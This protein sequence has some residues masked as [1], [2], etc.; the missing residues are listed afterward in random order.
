MVV[1]APSTGRATR[2]WAAAVAAG[3]LHWL[4]F[5]GVGLWPLAF[6]ALVPLYVSRVSSSRTAALAG[7]LTG[8]TTTFGICYWLPSAAVLMGGVSWMTGVLLLVLV[9]IVHGA[10]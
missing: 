10:R 7:G 3:F 4:A 6:V 1:S 2:W 8:F 5:P 9:A